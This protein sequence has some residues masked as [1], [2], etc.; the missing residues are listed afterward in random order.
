MVKM[1]LVGFLVLSFRQILIYFFSFMHQGHM[2]FIAISESTHFGL[3]KTILT[4][5][6]IFCKSWDSDAKYGKIG[7]RSFFSKNG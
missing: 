2:G 1:I 6:N 3:S 4:F 7:F 5:P